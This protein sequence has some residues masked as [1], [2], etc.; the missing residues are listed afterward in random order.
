MGSQRRL[1][2]TTD[3]SRRHMSLRGLPVKK[4][5]YTS[6]VAHVTLRAMSKLNGLCRMLKKSVDPYGA[7]LAYRTTSLECGYSPAQLPMGRELRTSIPV[8]A[9]TL[10]PRWDE[11]KQLRD[12]QD[13]IKIRHTVDYDRYNRA[14]PLI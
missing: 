10:Q 13:N 1:Y 5:S 11:S 14:H 9:W 7:L 4:A 3:R 12:R 2:P 8:M 6:L